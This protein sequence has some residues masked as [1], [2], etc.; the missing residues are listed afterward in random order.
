M[1]M[2][3]WVLVLLGCASLNVACAAVPAGGAEQSVEALDH[4]ETAPE[5]AGS[6]VKAKL[7]VGGRNYNAVWYL[8]AGP[9]SA[10]ISLQHGFSRSCKNQRDTTRQI[11]AAGL[12][13]LCLD[14]DMSGGNPR[15]AEALAATLLS[16]ITAPDGRSL[17]DALLVGGHS[18]G[19]AFAS[20]LGWQLDALAPERLRGALL[21]DA[22]AAD[23]FTPNLQAISRQG[24]RPVYS[25]TA[26]AGACN[27]S[28][29]AYPALRQL[30]RDALA[31]GRDGFIGLQLTRRSTHVDSEGNNT[32]LL[33]YIA[34]G[35][36]KPAADNTATLR[37]LASRWAAD[38]ASGSRTAAF[39]PGGAYVEWLLAEE[40]ALVI[41]QVPTQT[42]AAQLLRSS[43]GHQ[44]KGT[45]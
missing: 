43:A 18:A 6:I 38:I 7:N 21:F 23:N 1:K 24:E 8:P 32:D 42:G 13:A 10:L 34:C 5:A 16:G 15:L 20:R 26:N 9:A 4:D 22:V 25:V 12:M 35:Q 39:Y 33:G 3:G 14:A 45:P 30:Q 37:R 17:P 28:N 31:A 11:M 44:L 41:E 2:A 19:G 40:R 29:N 36:G 27:A